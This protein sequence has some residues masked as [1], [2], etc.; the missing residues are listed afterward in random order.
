MIGLSI[1][2]DGTLVKFFLLYWSR[3][4]G[5]LVHILSVMWWISQAENDPEWAVL[6]AVISGLLEYWYWATGANA[7]RFVDQY[8]SQGEDTLLPFKV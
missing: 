7:V 4:L 2:L 6:N 8:W 5:L 3:Y 1:G